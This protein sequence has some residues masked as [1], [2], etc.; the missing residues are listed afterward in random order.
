MPTKPAAIK[1]AKSTTLLG[2]LFT[3]LAAGIGSLVPAIFNLAVVLDWTLIFVYAIL[4]LSVGFLW[5]YVGILSFGQTAFFGLGGYAFAVIALNGIDPIIA[6][7][8][9]PVVGV[10]AAVLFGYFTIY[11]RISDVYLSVMTLVLT[12]VLDRAIRATA[13]MEIGDVS[14]N[15]QNGIPGLPWLSIP[16]DPPITLDLMGNYYLS[17]TLLIAT[18]WGLRLLLGSDFGRV[19]VGIRENERRIELLGYDSRRYKLAAFVICGGLAGLSGGLFAI[20]GNFVSPQMYHLSR[21]AEI[22]IWVIVGGKNTLLG[23]IVGVGIVETLTKWLGTQ[24]VGQVNLVLGIALILSV[25]A[26]KEGI[27]P[28]II[29]GIRRLTS[30]MFGRR[31]LDI[32]KAIDEHRISARS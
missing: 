13:G 17:G 7:A 19:L 6:L 14:L 4:G 22:I 21:S 5:G 3:L 18:Y 32:K 24:N 15:G 27:L 23:P 9:A 29:A 12:V 28:G 10:I 31:A 25:I 11:G 30:R 16:W 2:V 1:S 20:W 8:G 26:F